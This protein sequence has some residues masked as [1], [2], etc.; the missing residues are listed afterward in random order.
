[1]LINSFVKLNLSWYFHTWN[2]L[3]LR[4]N[5]THVGFAKKCCMQL[6]VQ[7]TNVFWFMSSRNLLYFYFVFTKLISCWVFSSWNL[8]MDF[9]PRET[10]FAFGTCSML[11]YCSW[12]IMYF[13]F[14]S[15]NFLQVGFSS[16]N[17]LYVSFVF[18]VKRNECWFLFVKPVECGLVLQET[19]VSWFTSS[20]V[21]ADSA[22][23]R[24]LHWFTLFLVNFTSY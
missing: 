18:F 21:V 23:P 9:S 11:V 17:L 1:M 20:T 2:L 8:H 24:S 10:R 5:M 15:G 19:N 12:N 4:E 16:W 7:E 14:S 3:K 22:S 13:D 6:F